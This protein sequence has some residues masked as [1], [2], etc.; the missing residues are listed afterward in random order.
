MPGICLVLYHR[1]SV[2]QHVNICNK[3]MLVFIYVGGRICMNQNLCV[4]LL[5][6]VRMERIKRDPW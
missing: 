6:K 2:K 1:D 4:F 5:R 3:C